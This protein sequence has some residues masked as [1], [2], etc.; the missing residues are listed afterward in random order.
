MYNTKIAFFYK[1]YEIV[2]RNYANLDW[3]IALFAPGAVVEV[4]TLVFVLRHSSVLA[5]IFSQVTCHG[6][7]DTE[8]IITSF[9]SFTVVIVDSDRHTPRK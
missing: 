3:F 4:I 1:N 8:T 2:E 6:S 7:R 9:T 5:G